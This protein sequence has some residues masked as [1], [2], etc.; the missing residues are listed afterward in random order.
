MAMTATLTGAVPSAATLA[1]AQSGPCPGRSPHSTTPGTFSQGHHPVV[2]IHGWGGTSDSMWPVEQGLRKLVPDTF[3]FRYFD[4]R[5]NRSDWAARAP[6]AS[7]LADYINEVSAHH[8][9]VGGDGKV[10]VVAHSMGGLAIRFATDK[11]TVPT[12]IPAS[13]LGGVVTI[14]TPHLG[15]VFGNTW[16]ATLAQW[17]QEHRGQSLLPGHTSDAARCLAIHGPGNDLPSDC[18]TPPFLPA[19]VH[20]AETAGTS[21]V[22][23]TLFGIDL[24]DIPLSSD[25]V[26]SVDSAHGYRTSGVNGTKAPPPGASLPMTSCTITSDQ[27]MALLQAAARGASLPGAIIG[28]EVKALQLLWKD[29]AILDAINAGQLTPDLE[30][31][32]G[33]ALFF[34]PCG[35]NAMLGNATTLQDVATALR[36]DLANGIGK[37]LVL[38]SKGLGPFHPGMTQSQANAAARNLGVPK[39]VPGGQFCSVIQ[40]ADRSYI[41]FLTGDPNKTVAV[42]DVGDSHPDVKTD[43]GV[44]IGSTLAA[45]LAA[46]PEATLGPGISGTSPT[47]IADYPDGTSIRFD[48]DPSTKRVSSMGGGEH[49]S[50]HAYEICG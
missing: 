50:V 7:C 26:V 17:A 40:P 19:G 1:T 28:A 20:L 22:R 14:D 6:V 3:D 32:L 13:A 43:R 47:V 21:T 31:L 44:S 37:P 15:S 2:L 39:A 11:N 33:T 27:T 8:R 12:P 16:Q 46:Y 29:G 45:V 23:R 49:N 35:H 38:T 48:V 24:Y 5:G 18:A 34:Y 36:A 41:V 42:V 25:G 4:Y 10:Y 30:V 9:A